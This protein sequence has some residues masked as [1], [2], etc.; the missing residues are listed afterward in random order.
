MGYKVKVTS[1]SRLLNLELRLHDRGVDGHKWVI[2]GEISS[3]KV[4]STSS[5]SR[6]QYLR[7][8]KRLAVF[9]D[10]C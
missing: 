7:S 10:D 8:Y 4:D 1:S 3:C 9:N 2:V 5:V 6:V